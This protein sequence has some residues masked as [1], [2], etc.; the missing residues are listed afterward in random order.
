MRFCS[1]IILF[2]YA[3]GL[4][5]C[6]PR[7]LL[8]SGWLFQREVP[9]VYR[10]LDAAFLCGFSEWLPSGF[11]NGFRPIQGDIAPVEAIFIDEKLSIKF[12]QNTQACIICFL[13]DMQSAA[14]GIE[15]NMQLVYRCVYV[16]RYRVEGWIRGTLRSI[17]GL[18]RKEEVLER[19]SFLTFC[20]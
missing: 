20:I 7:E 14:S 5:Y 16:Y 18:T 6:S 2:R 8:S 13:C 15:T 3:L 1:G 4:V 12:I 19:F 11:P 10:P 17:G 9:I